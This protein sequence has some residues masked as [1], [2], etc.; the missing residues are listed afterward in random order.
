[1]F[2][3]EQLNSGAQ[4]LPFGSPLCMAHGCPPPRTGVNCRKRDAHM[5]PVAFR[6]DEP[7]AVQ[8]PT[9]RMQ[10]APAG[11]G[12]AVADRDLVA[13]LVAGGLLA[14]AAPGR[15]VERAEGHHFFA[16]R[17]MLQDPHARACATGCWR[18]CRSGGGSPG[19]ESRVGHDTGVAP[20]GP[21]A[22]PA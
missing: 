19:G 5:L 17:A 6:R 8:Q 22:W 21:I 3:S 2:F 15:C 12:A 7:R 14:E 1:M 18:R 10:A 11:L 4:A 20:A 9:I 16:I 13:D